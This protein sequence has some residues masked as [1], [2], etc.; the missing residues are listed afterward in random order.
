MPERK[1]IVVKWRHVVDKTRVAAK[2]TKNEKRTCKACKITWLNMQI[3][4]HT[5][6]ETKPCK[7]EKTENTL[8]KFRPTKLSIL[9]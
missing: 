1:K 6:E 7:K 8:G 4:D 5:V 2:C 3:C 9:K